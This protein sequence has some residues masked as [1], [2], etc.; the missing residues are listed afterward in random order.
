MTIADK[1]GQ[2]HQW[3]SLIEH[4]MLSSK[5]LKGGGAVGENKQTNLA[6]KAGTDMR[7]EECEEPNLA[8]SGSP[9]LI[10]MNNQ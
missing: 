6:K 1:I 9:G 10:C 5:V 8:K 4:G 2:I 3:L 7:N